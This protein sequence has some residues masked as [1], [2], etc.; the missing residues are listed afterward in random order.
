M[1]SLYGKFGMNPIKTKIEMVH[2]NDIAKYIRENASANIISNND[3][4]ALIET[5]LP[6]AAG[7]GGITEL[8][9]TETTRKDLYKNKITSKSNVAIAAAIT[10]YARM[11][12]TEVM[13][14]ENNPIFYHD[15]DSVVTQHPLPDSIVGKELGMM[16]LEHKVDHA[17]FAGPKL[18]AL[19]T[20]DVKTSEPIEIIK[21]KG[22]GN[23]NLKFEDIE[24]LLRGEEIKADKEY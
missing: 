9:I 19:K 21:V 1:N 14:D 6:K 5:I 20:K 13:K 18:Y 23:D 3:D 24:S 7:E 22:F 11:A 2:V 8:L 15:T 4:Y 10:A 17:V 12:L 16:K